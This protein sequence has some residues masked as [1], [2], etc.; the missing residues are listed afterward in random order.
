MDGII[1]GLHEEEG[2]EVADLSALG[3]RG[4]RHHEDGEGGMVSDE[5]MEGHLSPPYSV[6]LMKKGLRRAVG[7]L[8][9]PG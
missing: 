8:S 4:G 7:G 9:H 1:H 6:S 5:A 2:E 3:G